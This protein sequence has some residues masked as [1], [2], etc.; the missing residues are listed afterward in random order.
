MA[1][2]TNQCYLLISI[3]TLIISIIVP[4]IFFFRLNNTFVWNQFAICLADLNISTLL[5]T[6]L[7]NYCN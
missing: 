2:H 4:A 3:I 5:L 1:N 6:A 7:N